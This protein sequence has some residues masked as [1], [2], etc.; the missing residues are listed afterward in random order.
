MRQLLAAEIGGRSKAVPAGGGPGGVGL[1]PA[2]RG[3]DMAVLEGRAELV[4]DA[5]ERRDHVG[6]ELAGFLEHRID[7]GF[8]EVAINAFG[9]GGSQAGGV[10]EGKSDV[11]NGGAVCHKRQSSRACGRVKGAWGARGTAPK[12]WG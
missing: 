11:G 3:G 1:L 9:D 5:V 7:G 2:G 6:G 10:F 8:V 4:A 12:S